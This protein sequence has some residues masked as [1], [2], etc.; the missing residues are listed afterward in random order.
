MKLIE[1]LQIHQADLTLQQPQATP[2]LRP[3]FMVWTLH[4]VSTLLVLFLLVT[5]LA[6]GLGFTKR[7]FPA[8]WMDWHL[9]A[10]VAL[11]VMTVV[12]MKTSHPW[13]GLTRAIAFGRWNT[14]AIKPVL[15]FAVFLVLF[16]GLAIFQKPPFGRAGTL[17]GLIP[18]PTLIRLNHSIHN[19]IID[20][21]IALS[22]IV[23]ALTITH[24][25]AG[26][27]RTPTYGRSLLAIMLWP[28]RRN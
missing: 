10:G 17:F 19:V 20:L 27:R 4:W 1:P 6:S 23:V 22:I 11:L 26:L 25:V 15:L 18:M 13:S 28:W 24:V 12:R 21:H 16:S 9:S 2:V 7:P 3:S 8:V 14:Q 5:S